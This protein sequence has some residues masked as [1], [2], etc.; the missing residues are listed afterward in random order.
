M[1]VLSLELKSKKQVID[2]ENLEKLITMYNDTLNLTSFA[3][4]SDMVFS[5]LDTVN[6]E[7]V[8]NNW[9]TG[10]MI[11]TSVCHD[12]KDDII[13]LNC[14]YDDIGAGNIL[15]GFNHY[16]YSMNDTEIEWNWL[17]IDPLHPD[18]PY[19]IRHVHPDN[20][21]ADT[22][23][24][25]RQI[26]QKTAYNNIFVS[27]MG[28]WKSVMTGLNVL[29]KYGM[30]FIRLHEWDANAL[31]IIEHI[32]SVASCEIICTPWLHIYLKFNNF[33]DYETFK[34]TSTQDL[35]KNYKL[36]HIDISWFNK[37]KKIIKPM[38]D[39]G[40]IFYQEYL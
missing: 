33:L 35:L 11:A 28:T 30:G 19:N 37:L 20:F 23:N 40:S 9:L 1:Q 27:T 24:V 17:C 38:E 31:K 16:I 12:M 5:F 29:N 14:I 21:I 4:D 2:D 32:L 15:S 6:A 10:W 7:A 13:L 8:D 39:Y 3:H 25:V 18:D 22:I 26:Q 36:Q 34:C